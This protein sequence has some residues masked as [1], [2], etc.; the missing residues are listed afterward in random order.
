[1]HNRSSTFQD[2]LNEKLQECFL[3]RIRHAMKPDE[4]FGL[5]FSWDNVI[6]SFLFIAQSELFGLL[7]SDIVCFKGFLGKT[8]SPALMNCSSSPIKL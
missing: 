5:I 1:V 4:A 6:V 3:Q 8:C 2:Y 7:V